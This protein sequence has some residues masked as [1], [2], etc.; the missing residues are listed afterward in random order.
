MGNRLDEL[1][2]PKDL[3]NFSL[4]ELEEMAGDC[5]ER[6]ID[7]IS[8]T[9]GH[10][11]SSLG[12]VELTVA[13]AKVFDFGWDK[14]V[15][16]VGHQ[17]YT[18][19][20]LTGRQELFE[21]LGKKGGMAKFLSREESKYDY[22]GAGHAS[23]SIS[24]A[25]GIG[26][27]G[28]LKGENFKSIA[29]IGD[30][31]MTGGLAFEALNHAG[32]LDQNLIVIFNDN[33]MSIDPVVGALSKTIINISASKSYNKLREQIS[34][35]TKEKNFPL[36]IHNTLKKINESFMAFFTQGVWF[37]KLNFRYFGQVDGHNIKDL[38]SLLKVAKSLNGPVL[39]HIATQKGR[40]YSPAEGNAL[41]YHG[42]S[43][44][45]RKSGKQIKGKVEGRSYTSIWSECFDRI[46]EEDEK[47]VGISAAMLGNTGLAPL[48]VKYP[49]RIFDVGI[50]EGH[51][52]T[53]AGGLAT[54]KIKP[55]VV[56]Y[57][58]FLQRAFDHIV[59]DI[60][61]QKLPVRFILDRAGFVGPDG[62]THHGL[63]DMSYLRMIPNM[64]I[65]APKDGKELQRMVQFAHCY[66]EG[67]IALRFPRGN[68]DEYY[69][70]AQD[71]IPEL[72]FG[73]GELLQSGTDFLL[74]AAGSMVKTAC[75]IAEKLQAKGFSIGIIN[76]RFIK[77]LDQKLILEEVTKV[78]YIATLEENAKAGGFGSGILEFLSEQEVY[79]PVIQFGAPDHFIEF[80]TPEQQLE[81]AGLDAES[82]TAK[83]EHFWN[84]YNP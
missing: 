62:A 39:I 55:F 24:A 33:E 23:T 7:V 54:E 71:N 27:A 9:G 82:I 26:T 37:E 25:L 32:H 29:V 59:H 53:F 68:T 50:A 10:L 17:A 6:I 60:A 45:E 36:A 43:A 74:L 21:Q 73:K 42:V 61:L 48:Q 49:E 83:L 18:Y 70:L 5:R 79:K 30:G 65:M 19:K 56:V 77:P 57:S 72:P 31:S 8:R 80:A 78:K 41:S 3:Q 15:W 12:V 52:V 16:D 51:A 47:T 64:V 11:A 38:V 20:L 84:Q 1:K 66:D 44:F 81:E 63:L 14:V 4:K 67:P 46:M 75:C 69:A 22:F 13:L 35:Q 58:T 34:L 40:G 28:S 2:S 76:A